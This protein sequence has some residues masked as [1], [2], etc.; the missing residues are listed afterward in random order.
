M[1]I[2]Q[3]GGNK[4]QDNLATSMNKKTGMWKKCQLEVYRP[5]HKV[6]MET[7]AVIYILK[8]ELNLEA[9]PI[10]QWHRTLI[11]ATVIPISLL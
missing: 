4:C 9:Q 10:V 8:E 2:L 3:W 7:W 6:E 11:R 1:T 5:S